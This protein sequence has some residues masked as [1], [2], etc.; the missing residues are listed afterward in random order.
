MVGRGLLPV[1][2]TEQGE[3]K[4]GALGSIANMKQRVLT[5]QIFSD[6]ILVV[7]PAASLPPVLHL[8]L[9]FSPIIFKMKTFCVT[10]KTF[11]L[12]RSFRQ[13]FEVRY[14]VSSEKNFPVASCSF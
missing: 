5:S 3:G 10:Y 9:I 2:L 12:Q 6:E 13:K 1:N 7:L 8:F 11:V 4:E 14:L